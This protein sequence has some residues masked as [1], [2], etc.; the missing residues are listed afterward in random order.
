MGFLGEKTK[1]KMCGW[2]GN[3]I[4]IGGRMTKIVTCLSST[5]VYQMSM[6]LLHKATIEEI[7]KPV[8]FNYASTWMDC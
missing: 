8:R 7:D 2:V 3:N 4:S 1:E 5:G 6:I